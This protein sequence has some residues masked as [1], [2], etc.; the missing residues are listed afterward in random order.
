MNICR[1][2]NNPKISKHISKTT[3]TSKRRAKAATS[4]YWNS[5]RSQLEGNPR[6]T[7]QGR[8]NFIGALRLLSSSILSCPKIIRSIR[9]LR[10]L[11]G[12][13]YKL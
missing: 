5:G 9:P 7:S 3:T 4:V 8:V 11:I 6:N 12:N 10:L 2:T 1:V 13:A